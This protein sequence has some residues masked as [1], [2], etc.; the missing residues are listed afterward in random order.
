[1]PKCLNDEK[2]YYKGTEPSPKGLGYS[3]SGEEVD[4]E[5]IGKDGFNWIVIQTK[6][7]K[8][9]VK[10]Q[11]KSEETSK[12][13]NDVKPEVSTDVKSKVN[14]EVSAEVKPKTKSKPKKK[15]IDFDNLDENDYINAY[16]P[17]VSEKEIT[18]ETGL[19]E[20]FGGT[21]PFFIEGE[22]WPLINTE[23]HMKLL[24]QFK[25]PRKKDNILI[26]IFSTIDEDN[27]DYD[28]PIFKVLKIELN[29]EN[30]KKQIVLNI[31]SFKKPYKGYE[32]KKWNSSKELKPLLYI[33]NKYGYT[34][35]PSK[36][37]D[38]YYDSPYLPSLGTKVGGT[39]MYC[40]Y[41]DNDEEPYNFLQLREYKYCPYGWGDSGIAHISER[42]SLDWD[43]Y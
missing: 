5:M 39:P 43:C 16:L 14:A 41:N 6:T 11:A 15:V 9:W 12:V 3:A 27:E 1:M 18:D 20:K 40:Q 7:C 30:L 38:Q 24:I 32:I 17:D 22:S 42:G 26:R 29:E 35:T 28:D 13:N 37:N 19:E 33:M 21:K 4:E 31:P 23:E 25:D 36:Y 34:K 2:K 10:V 8:K